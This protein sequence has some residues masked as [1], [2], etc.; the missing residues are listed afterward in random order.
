MAELRRRE[1][2]SDPLRSVAVHFVRP[3]VCNGPKKRLT[4]GLDGAF[5]FQAALST[6]SY[7]E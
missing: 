7:R 6:T 2:G 1:S 5:S 4:G 3:K